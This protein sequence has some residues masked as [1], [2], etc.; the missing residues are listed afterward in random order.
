MGLYFPCKL[1]ILGGS[2]FPIKSGLK[3]LAVLV[4]FAKNCFSQDI[5]FSQFDGSLLNISPA[6]TGFFFGDFRVSAIYRSQW[7]SV[8][9]PYSTISM[10][11]EARIKPRSFVKDMVGIGVTFNNDVA[12]DARYGTTNLYFSGSYINPLKQDSSLLLSL[13]MNI[14]WCQVGFDYNKMT[15]DNQFDGVQYSAGTPSGEK[16]DW[17]RYNYADANLG[18]ALQYRLNNKHYFS[19]GMGFDHITTPVITYQGN[20]LSKLDFKTIN[21]LRYSVIVNREVDIIADAMINKQGKYYE[22][23]PHSSVK[24]YFNRDNNKAV[25]GGLS[26]RARDALVVRFGYTEKTLQSGIAYDINISKFTAATNR[27]GAFEI[28]VNYIIR[29]QSAY[30][31][32]KRICPVFM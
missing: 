15:F 18:A 26:F 8:P 6:F 24:Y 27:R 17:Y 32:K 29:K 2:N 30:T 11:G 23:L 12:G 10:S 25:L 28:F 7:Q 9:V 1:N 16:F 22:I 4:L 20:M 31:V 19:L 13:G 14:G 21:Y 3:Y 5:H